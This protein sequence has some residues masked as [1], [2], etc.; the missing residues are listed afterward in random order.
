MASL[1]SVRVC[2]DNYLVFIGEEYTAKSVNLQR[3]SLGSEGEGNMHIR[4]DFVNDD[5]I[6][7]KKLSAES[8]LH[9]GGDPLSASGD[10]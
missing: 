3:P 1:E 6:C 2:P 9:R 7:L 5:F 4:E 10:R 8:M